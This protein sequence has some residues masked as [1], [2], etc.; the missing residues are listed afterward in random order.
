[1]SVAPTKVFYGPQDRLSQPNLRLRVGEHILDVGTLRLTTRPDYPRLTSKAVAVLLQLVR[2]RG[3]TVTRDELL[4]RVWAD[5][6]TTQDVLTQAIKELR[7]A[8]CDDAKPSRYIETI[9]KVGYR[10]L[11]DVAVLDADAAGMDERALAPVAVN[12]PYISP[13]SPAAS[14][15]PAQSRT[16][17]PWHMLVA[18][19]LLV[20][21][22]VIGLAVFLRDTPTPAEVNRW[23]V[24]EVRS[25]T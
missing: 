9:P 19:A 10:L 17:W 2:Q 15:M 7:R 25:L 13:P 22:A 16:G 23:Q 5:R 11:A 14:D 21:V 3:A 8:F 6:V 24:G 20:A 4:D 1:M 12:D 18:L